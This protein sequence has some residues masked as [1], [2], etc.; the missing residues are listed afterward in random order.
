MLEVAYRRDVPRIEYTVESDVPAERVWA[1]ITD[2][3]ERRPEWWPNLSPKFYVLHERG[4]NW[5]DCT[6]GTDAPGGGV[7]ARERYEWSGNRI[8][9]TPKESNVFRPGAGTWAMTVDPL[10]DGGSKVHVLNHRHPKGK[11]YAASVFMTFFGKRLLTKQLLQTL[12]ILRREAPTAGGASTA[13]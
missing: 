9:A 5:A 11:G 4:E 12:D 10:P 7:W 3:S 1:A 13:P 2:F 6:E 8:T